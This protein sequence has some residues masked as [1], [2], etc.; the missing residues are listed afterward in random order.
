MVSPP[1]KELR[2]LLPRYRHDNLFDSS[3]FVARFPQFGV[4]ALA[5]GLEAIRREKSAGA[6]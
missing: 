1:V 5:E 4:T 3:R 2:E 6:A